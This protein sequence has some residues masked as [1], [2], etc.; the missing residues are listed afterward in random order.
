M[1]FFVPRR[2]GPLTARNA[3]EVLEIPKPCKVADYEESEARVRNAREL[4]AAM[5]NER[6]LGHD[7]GRGKWHSKMRSV[8]V[9]LGNCVYCGEAGHRQW[10]CPVADD[11]KEVL[12]HVCG[13][14][15]HS[16]L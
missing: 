10:D 15:D 2:I 14:R 5:I 7:V 16:T 12:C 9:E 11:N 3:D 13:R 4:E 8:L 6:R 1:T